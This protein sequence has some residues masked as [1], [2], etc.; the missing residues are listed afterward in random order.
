MTSAQDA[1]A[2]WIPPLA[3]ALLAGASAGLAGPLLVARRRVLQTNLIAHAVLPGL[4]VAL[5][6]G[7][8]PLLGGLA[9]GLLATALVDRFSSHR[10]PPGPS[11][12]VVA[13][14]LLAASLGLAV[15]LIQGLGVAVDLND[16][17]FGDL[18]TAGRDDLLRAGLALAL[19]LL[20]LGWRQRELVF[21]AVD[22]EGAAAAGL[23]VRTLEQLLNLATALVV[24]S[25]MASVGLILAI[26]LVCAPAQVGLST[27]SSLG[28]AMRR[29]A[30]LG[31]GVACGGFGLGLLLDTPPG[32]LIACLGVPLLL[33]GDRLFTRA[34]GGRASGRPVPKVGPED[35]QAAGDGTPIQPNHHPGA[36]ESPPGAAAAGPAS[37]RRGTEQPGAA[38]PAE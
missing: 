9:A 12:E 1:M 19:L 17:L 7:L 2:W 23:P 31:M 10:A 5:A 29:S 11:P 35:A 18:L 24:V 25:A 16:L 13:N 15:V 21:L 20:L 32:P 28:Q 30:A 26:A 6:T 33:W 22:P 8:D 34:S 37:G 38:P 14:T 3:M 36:P 27:A 4:A